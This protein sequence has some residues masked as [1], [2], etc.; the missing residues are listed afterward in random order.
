MSASTQ[1]RTAGFYSLSAVN[2]ETMTA[3]GASVVCVVNRKV[4]KVRD[5][6][7]GRDGNLDFSILGM[8][9]V[10]FLVQDFVGVPKPGNTLLDAF[11]FSHRIRYVLHTDITW[12]C[13][14]TPSQIPT[15]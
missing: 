1:I 4:G 14:C 8:S 7:Q 10:E 9:E 15:A 3:G 6:L 11:G 5:G 2:G 12:V 13:Y